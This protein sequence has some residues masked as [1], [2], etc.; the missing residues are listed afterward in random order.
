MSATLRPFG[1]N[2]VSQPNA[3]ETKGT[4]AGKGPRSPR[5]EPKPDKSDQ[6]E[7]SPKRSRSPK[8]LEPLTYPFADKYDVMECGGGGACGYLAL[9]MALGLEKGESEANVRAV[10]Q[11]RAT[12]IRHDIY[13]HLEKHSEEY[14]T[15]YCPAINGNQ[16]VEDGETP[17]DWNSFM[18]ATLRAKRWI[19][20]ISLLAAARRY[21][22][23]I[24][25]IPISRD[26]KDTPMMFGTP[27][28]GKAPIFLLLREGHYQL[29]RLKPGKQWP[30]AWMHAE[31]AAVTASCL[32]GGGKPSP[33]AGP[34]KVVS[35]P[36]SKS[37]RPACTPSPSAASASVKRPAW[38]DVSTPKRAR[39]GDV[40]PLKSATSNRW[41]EAE[42]PASGWRPLATP[43]T[44]SGV[45]VK[46]FTKPDK[47]GFQS[48]TCPTCGDVLKGKT[49]MQLAAKRRSHCKARHP[50]V[51][52]KSYLH[53]AFIQTLDAT[54]DLPEAERDWRC[55]VCEAAL[56][57]QAR[58]VR[59]LSVTH[60]RKAKHPDMTVAE[61][62]ALM[63]KAVQAR[64]PRSS[65][66]NA[67]CVKR[68][69]E[70]RSKHFKTHRIVAIA[71]TGPKASQFRRCMEYWCANCLTKVGGYG[72][73][74]ARFATLSLP[75][76]NP[77][78]SQMQNTGCNRPGS[79]SRAE[80]VMMACQS[81][82]PSVN[83]SETCYRTGT[84]KGNLVRARP[85][86]QR[87]VL[88]LHV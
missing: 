80:C 44:S 75:A 3:K 85:P 53:R 24:T 33:W 6:G 40:T 72:G 67:A 66:V 8:S 19:D 14:R 28:S 79:G 87:P 41:R 81:T 32:R 69:E 57:K 16:D 76:P 30:Q 62:K 71:S 36:G 65:K 7:A 83:G 77:S 52:W 48:W 54:H 84:L 43:D 5:S 26:P 64:V 22:V 50:D 29:A 37:W 20:G 59:T 17:T 34:Q 39:R 12:T 58:R 46:G 82:R 51:P 73:G 1:K 21:G 4:Y 38:R 88:Q 49:Y 68:G 31:S 86:A 11:T 47:Q 45:V 27:R 9:A 56:P 23:M 74:G 35:T 78:A 15:W 70:Y 55:P 60:H 13:K 2:F 10:L 63:W 18:Q 42:T 25:V 61:W